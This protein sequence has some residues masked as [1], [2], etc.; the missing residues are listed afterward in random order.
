MQVTAAAAGEAKPRCR[1]AT[2]P[3]RTDRGLGRVR[4][5]G[6]RESATG[7]LEDLIVVPELCDE[8]AEL[9]PA[10]LVA[11]P[12]VARGVTFGALV[13]VRA[14][15]RYADVDLALA[16]EVAAR[17]ALPLD[18]ARMYEE[19]AY[20]ARTLQR[21]LR[22]PSLPRIP[23]VRLASRYRSAIE[24]LEIGGDFYDVHGDSNDWVAVIGDVCGKG[25]EAAVL[26][27]RSRQTI[28]TVTHLDRSPAKILSVLND[29]LYEVDSDRFVTAACARL[30]PEADGSVR[31]DVASAGHPTP[32][33]LRADGAVERVNAHGVLSGVL[34]EV[35]YHEVSV[36]LADGDTLLLY[37]DGIYE[38]RGPAGFYGMHRLLDLLPDYAGAAPE[39]VC[40]AVE[41]S[42][43]EHLCGR[44]HDDMA[45]LA[46]TC[47][48]R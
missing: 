1:T 29:V 8:V 2:A 35:A 7:S 14:H 10:D 43:V 19:R 28:Q 24:H 17:I 32:L 34:S 4:H 18:A 36:R 11:V 31:V 9:D 22:P 3:E 26:T 40:G 16:D 39:V 41:Q 25:V 45:L 15:H 42:V 13:L 21:N 37:T 33:V 44:P 23:G 48:D 6:Q 47:G 46:V 27:G 20:I 38:A 12:L 30:R 5:T